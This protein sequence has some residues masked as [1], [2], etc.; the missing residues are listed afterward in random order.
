M[1]AKFNQLIFK[2]T[3]SMKEKRKKKL[4]FQLIYDFNCTTSEPYI[5]YTIAPNSSFVNCQI[6][7]MEFPHSTF[8]MYIQA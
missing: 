6:L 5:S 1:K 4:K 8:N 3:L 7:T 2:N